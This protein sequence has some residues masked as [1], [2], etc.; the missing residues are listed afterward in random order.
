M[1]SSYENPIAP[2]RETI[3]RYRIEVEAAVRSEFEQIARN[4]YGNAAVSLQVIEARLSAKLDA[5]AKHAGR[6]TKRQRLWIILGVIG[7]LATVVALAIGSW[8]YAS[9]QMRTIAS[10]REQN[11]AQLKALDTLGARTSGVSVVKWNTGTFVILPK[12]AE[13]T[14]RCNGQ[15]CIKLGP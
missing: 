12:T 5:V 13:M 4:L 14:W 6:A 7:G 10:L 9:T 1:T 2:V 15:P 8:A 11:A 3:E